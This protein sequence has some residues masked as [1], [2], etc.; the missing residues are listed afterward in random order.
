L[1]EIRLREKPVINEISNEELNELKKT[2]EENKNLEY[3][4]KEFEREIK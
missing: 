1:F 3:L 4:N 2:K